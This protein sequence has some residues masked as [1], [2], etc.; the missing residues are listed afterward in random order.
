MS[1]P[2]LAFIYFVVKLLNSFAVISL[3]RYHDRK[4]YEV[5][6][7]PTWGRQ[8]PGGPHVGPVNLAFW[9]YLE[10]KVFLWIPF[11]KDSISHLPS[12]QIFVV[13][14]TIC[15]VTNMDKHYK[16]CRLVNTKLMKFWYSFWKF[17]ILWTIE[18]WKN[19]QCAIVSVGHYNKYI[20]Y[21]NSVI[22]TVICLSFSDSIMNCLGWIHN[23]LRVVV[24]SELSHYKF[25]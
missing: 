23:D 8:D 25:Y 20:N 3:L 22:V 5:N 17:Y 18:K 12:F 7:G 10:N 21:I 1:H 2:S 16:M 15:Q 24:I 9:V 6:M 4:F 13:W 19:I 14:L 11:T